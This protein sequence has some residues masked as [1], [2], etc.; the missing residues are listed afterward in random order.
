[1]HYDRGLK[2]ENPYN[3]SVLIFHKTVLRVFNSESLFNKLI[4]FVL[5]KILNKGFTNIQDL[6]SIKKVAPEFP[7]PLLRLIKI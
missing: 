3:F 4:S 6:E 5:K 1:M 7:M 2:F